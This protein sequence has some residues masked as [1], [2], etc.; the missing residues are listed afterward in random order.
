MLSKPNL[1]PLFC[2]ERAV[3]DLLGNP[4]PF[5]LE[6]VMRLLKFSH[7]ALAAIQSPR[8]VHPMPKAKTAPMKKPAAKKSAG[9]GQADMLVGPSW[10]AWLDH[11]KITGP[12][13]LWVLT[14]LCHLLC[15]RVTE[16]LKL[17]REDVDLEAGFVYV[18]PLK[19]QGEVRKA[20]SKAAK[21]IFERFVEDG[22]ATEQ[23]TRK[24]GSRGVV[25]IHDRWRFPTVEEKDA[26]LFPP[27]RKDSKLDRMNKDTNIKF[28]VI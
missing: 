2:D 11:L 4:L 5:L 6:P 12:T 8:L 23:R 19:R 28:R 22:G 15:C 20:L 21:E 9:K 25:T 26:Y 24:C 14:T 1:D 17:Q 7:E 13:W 3:D 18:G 16:V 27:V 10:R